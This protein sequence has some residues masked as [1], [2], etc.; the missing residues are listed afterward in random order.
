MAKLKIKQLSIKERMKLLDEVIDLYTRIGKEREDMD[1]MLF[2]VAAMVGTKEAFEYIA[3]EVLDKELETEDDIKQATFLLLQTTDFAQLMEDKWISSSD[4]FRFYWGVGL[5]I[6]I[7][8]WEQELIK[9]YEEVRK[10]REE[11]NGLC[12]KVNLIQK[13]I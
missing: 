6:W 12:I 9:D 2:K 1:Y 5:A 8:R 13:H 4:S 3:K 7:L 10:A 11:S